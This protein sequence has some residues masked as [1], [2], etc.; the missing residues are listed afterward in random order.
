MIKPLGRPSGFSNAGLYAIKLSKT[1]TVMTRT[2]RLLEMP[3][4]ITDKAQ[5]V[6]NAKNFNKLT[7]RSEDSYVYQERVF[8]SFKH[9]YY[10]EEQ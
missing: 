2:F 3:N 7:T 1:Q 9:W 10:F 4:T 8:N 6:E 5:A